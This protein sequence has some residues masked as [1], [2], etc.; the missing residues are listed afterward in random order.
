[1][2]LDR[3]SV[4]LCPLLRTSVETRWSLICKTSL[5]QGGGASLTD[6][7][8]EEEESDV[9]DLCEM[10]LHFLFDLHIITSSSP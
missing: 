1:M 3:L 10:F 6:G 7:G 4:D 5:I 2:L 8:E 9:F